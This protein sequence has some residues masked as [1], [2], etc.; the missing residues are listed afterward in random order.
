[1]QGEETLKESLLLDGL[2]ERPPRATRLHIAV[3]FIR[4]DCLRIEVQDLGFGE[5]FPS[6]DLSW[7]EEIELGSSY[8]T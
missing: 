2:P 6:S 3:E 7:T 5:L 4:V 8:E 1:M